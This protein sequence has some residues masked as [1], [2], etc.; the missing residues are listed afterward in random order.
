[1][2]AAI[3]ADGSLN[4]K[5][6]SE[7]E[8]LCHKIVAVAASIRHFELNSK[9][10]SANAIDVNDSNNPRNVLKLEVF[11]HTIVACKFLKNLQGTSHANQ[12]EKHGTFLESK[13]ISEDQENPSLTLNL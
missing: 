11:I 7:N 8:H 12:L 1:M 2:G 5:F 3:Q 13:K 10:K 9:P 6:L 4:E